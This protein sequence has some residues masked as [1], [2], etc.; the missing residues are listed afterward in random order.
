MQSVD[1]HRYNRLDCTWELYND[2]TGIPTVKSASSVHGTMIE[3]CML[4]SAGLRSSI[5]SYHRS[6]ILYHSLLCL[7]ITGSITCI[8][9]FCI[10]HSSKMLLTAKNLLQ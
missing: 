10:L 1:I 9:A 7:C 4:L 3:C 6:T 5:Q 8:I 2:G